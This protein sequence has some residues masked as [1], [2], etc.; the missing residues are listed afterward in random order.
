M[1]QSIP[2]EQNYDY[3]FIIVGSGFGGSVSAYRL[4]QKGYKV[5]VIES[6]KRWK[7]T[8]FP[9]TNWSLRKYLWMPKLGF[10]GIQRIN[11]LN[12][13]LLVS[14]AGVGGGSLVYACTLYVP[15]AKVL[16]SPLYSKMGGE[17]SLLPYYDVAKHMLGVTENPQLWE[18]DQLLLETAKTFGKEDTFR[19]T[20]VGI[21]FGNKKDPKDPFFGGDGPDRD[22]CNFCGGCMVGCRHNA[23]NTLDKNYLYLAEKLGA[24]ILPETKVTS[25]VPLNE[26]GIPDPE[27]S[28]EFGYELES[29]STTGWFGY[30]KRK[31]RS[32]QVVLSAGVMGTVGL[33]LKMQFENKMIRL[34]EKLGD[35]VRTNSE[36]V[37]P[38]T[39]PA[40]KNVDYSRGIA[41]TS[42]VHPDENTHIEP[43]RYSKGSDFFALLASVM[44]DGGGKFPRPL[45]F[46]WTMLRHP[47]YFLK[48]HN[49]VGF[50]KNSIILLV[51]QTVDN[52]VRLVRKRRIIWP[53]QRT[54]TSALSTGEPTPTYIPIANAFTRKLAEIVGGIPRSSFNDTLLSAP[55]T[56]HI[57]GGCIVA[58]SAE[59]GVIDMENKVFGYENLRVCDASMLTVNLGVNPSLTITALSE[60][61]MSFVPTKNK[62]ATQFLSF[63]I[64]KGFDKILSSHPKKSAVK[65]STSVRTRV[66]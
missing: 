56:G 31:F 54:I 18:P 63:E 7:S 19:R 27:A 55:L 51:M 43:V 6:G 42:S 49:P 2:K 53:F 25:L 32:K 37:L 15:S 65:K 17:K 57:M 64:K 52:S 8:D 45:K 33:L 13:F 4:S 41:I 21:Y 1:S 47:I 40:S 44:T 34:S 14:G 16:N 23:K 5:L 50:A 58:D 61:A 11:L 48:A 39:V 66:S 9:K 10:Y 35:T 20:P 30:P 29:N 38:V 62:T 12:D 59:R 3:D 46:F 28:G 60:R 36:T 24:E 22:P 26:K